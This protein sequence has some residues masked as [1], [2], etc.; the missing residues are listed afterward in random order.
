MLAFAL[1]PSASDAQT[2]EVEV[3]S[4]TLTPWQ[5]ERPC[6]NTQAGGFYNNP[7]AACFNRL[8]NAENEQ[9]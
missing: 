4:A 7:G 9:T 1:T 8:R 2:Q 3:W 5:A 6:D